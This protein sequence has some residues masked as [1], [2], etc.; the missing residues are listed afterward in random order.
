[1]VAYCSAFHPRV[2][3]LFNLGYSYCAGGSKLRPDVY[4][5]DNML[6]ATGLLPVG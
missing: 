3:L 5:N 2:A 4:P 6:N 1:M